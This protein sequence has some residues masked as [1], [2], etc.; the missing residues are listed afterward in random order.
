MIQ[1]LVSQVVADRVMRHLKPGQAFMVPYETLKGIQKEE[2]WNGELYFPMPGEPDLT[3]KGP[4]D[5]IME[6]IPNATYKYTI[7]DVCHRRCIEIEQLSEPLPDDDDEM[8]TFVF[9]DQREYFNKLSNGL[10]Q[11]KREFQTC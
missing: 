11:R 7:R 8:Q 6:K 4:I 9:F 1:H 10:Y 3:K 5:C 2:C